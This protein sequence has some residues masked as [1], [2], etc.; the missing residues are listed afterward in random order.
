MTV[1]KTEPVIFNDFI[2]FNEDELH[3]GIYIVVLH[4]TRIPPHIGLIIDKQYHSLTVKGHDYN[5]PVRAL[6]KNIEQRRIPSLFIKIKSHTT[7]SNTY[8][9]EHFIL[10]IQ[11][12]PRV[13]K[14]VATCLSPIKLFFDETYAVPMKEVNFLFDLL[15][16][17]CNEQLIEHSYSLKKKK[18]EYQLPLYTQEQLD[19]EIE[20][21]RTEV[22]TI[23]QPFSQTP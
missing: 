5:T 11:Q 15:P 3:N 7:F 16:K 4:A 19:T 1:L 13:D 20:N 21:V 2:K 22:N 14:N 10:N 9:K 12:F 6:I 8:L 18:K 23:I 17:L